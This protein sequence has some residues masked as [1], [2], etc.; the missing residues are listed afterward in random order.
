MVFICAKRWCVEPILP[1]ADRT[2]SALHNSSKMHSTKWAFWRMNYH[3]LLTLPSQW[4]CDRA[5]FRF[6]FFP[7]FF[8]PYSHEIYL[9]KKSHACFCAIK[10]HSIHIVHCSCPWRTGG[11]GSD[12]LGPSADAR[13]GN[14]RGTLSASTNSKIKRCTLER[15]DTAVFKKRWNKSTVHKTI[16]PS[17]SLLSLCL[18]HDP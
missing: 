9:G 7:F 3:R 1:P 10:R 2:T 17:A 14:A 4:L 8:S 11:W 6:L 12:A 5:M 18:P 13:D 15:W 16:I